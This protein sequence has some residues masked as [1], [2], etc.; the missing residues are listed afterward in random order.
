M[1]VVKVRIIGSKKAC[2][3]ILELITSQLP[4]AAL[5]EEPRKVERDP[6]KDPYNSTFGKAEAVYYLRLKPAWIYVQKL[7]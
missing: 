2:K 5:E 3:R 4:A 1:K 6:E 7:A